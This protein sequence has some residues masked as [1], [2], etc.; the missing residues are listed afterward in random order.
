MAGEFAL[1]FCPFQHVLLPAAV[2]YG[3][4]RKVNGFT[5]KLVGEMVFEHCPG[6]HVSSFFRG[7]TRCLNK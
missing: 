7:G 5:P 2:I 4:V 6:H 1:E 3:N